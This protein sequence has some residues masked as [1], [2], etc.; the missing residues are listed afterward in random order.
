MA[1]FKCASCG[2]EVEADAWY[3][4]EIEEGREEQ[5]CNNCKNWRKL[6]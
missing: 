4:K 3:I 2:K 1:Y 6:K 5:L